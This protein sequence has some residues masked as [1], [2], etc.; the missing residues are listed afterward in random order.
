MM[1]GRDKR[2]GTWRTIILT[3]SCVEEEA[4]DAHEGGWKG[5]DETMS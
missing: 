1:D 4:I 2:R 5:T 3:H